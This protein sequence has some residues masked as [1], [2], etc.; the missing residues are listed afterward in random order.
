[1]LLYVLNKSR[2]LISTRMGIFQQDSAP[3]HARQTV[4]RTARLS[5]FNA[6]R[7]GHPSPTV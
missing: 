3:S 6:T 5:S 2:K 4:R 7:F 1:M